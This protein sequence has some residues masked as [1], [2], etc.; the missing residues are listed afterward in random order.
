MAR[1]GCYR[2]LFVPLHNGE[3]P[4]IMHRL[5]DEPG[6]RL[7][8]ERIHTRGLDEFVLQLRNGGIVLG[9]HVDLH[10]VKSVSK[11]DDDEDERVGVQ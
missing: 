4:W 1:E 11:V 9:T 8:V 5:H 7:F 10:L 2:F 6:H 3:V